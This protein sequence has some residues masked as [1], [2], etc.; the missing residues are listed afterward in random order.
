MSIAL[1]VLFDSLVMGFYADRQDV[2]GVGDNFPSLPTDSEHRLRMKFYGWVF[3]LPSIP[4]LCGEPTYGVTGSRPWP[5][6]RTAESW[7]QV[8]VRRTPLPWDLGD[9]KSEVQG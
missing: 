1:V 7:I 2:G 6:V 8:G 9:R 4:R 5:A 3:A